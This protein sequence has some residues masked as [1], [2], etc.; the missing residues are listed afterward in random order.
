MSSG[1]PTYSPGE[2]SP[3]INEHALRVHILSKNE[4]KHFNNNIFKLFKMTQFYSIQEYFP[5]D[6]K[7]NTK[8]NVNNYFIS[9][10]SL[11][12]SYCLMDLPCRWT[13]GTKGLILVR[14]RKGLAKPSKQWVTGKRILGLGSVGV[15]V[16]LAGES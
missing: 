2:N 6:L 4:T 8:V 15:W 10:V 14:P 1:W 11:I 13:K 12:H 5:Q 9:L 7:S 3:L 16:G